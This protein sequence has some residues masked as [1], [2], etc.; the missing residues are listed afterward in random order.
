MSNEHIYMVII[1]SVLIALLINLLLIKIQKHKSIGQT[2]RELGPKSHRFK[3][4]TP[5]MGGIG[6]IISYA[7]VI[8]YIKYNLY[9]E[10]NLMGVL[11]PVISYAILGLLDD[12][13]ILFKQNNE[14]INA[15]IK[16]FIQILIATIYFYFLVNSE[17]ITNVNIFGKIIDLKWLY[18]ILVLLL[19]TSFTNA[20]NITDGIDGLLGGTMIISLFAIVL[21]SYSYDFYGS[22]TVLVMM[23]SILGFLILNYPKASIF[24]G[25]VGAYALGA[26]LVTMCVY[27]KLEIYLLLIGGIYILEMLSVLIQVTYFKLTKGKRIF[28]MAPLHHHFELMGYNEKD[29]LHLFYI[30]EII[31]VYVCIIIF[32]LIG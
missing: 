13:L 17:F 7:S 29:V 32:K 23:S 21:I 25:N 1:T 30:I 12:L 28:K 20:T 16:F 3:N 22:I 27:L 5:T 2:E 10:I 31:F 8:I 11:F 24:M 15:T 4:N 9:Y 18:G 19:F 6:F 26:F 14:G